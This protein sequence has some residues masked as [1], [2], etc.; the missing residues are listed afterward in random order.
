MALSPKELEVL[1]ETLRHYDQNPHLRGISPKGCV[2]RV[3][4]E[5]A[6]MCAVGRCLTPEAS[7]VA[8][9][10]NATAVDVL[11]ERLH[12]Y[13]FPMDKGFDDMFQ[14]AYRDLDVAFWLELQRVHDSSDIWKSH[15]PGFIRTRTSCAF[16]EEAFPV[17]VRQLYDAGF[18]TDADA[19]VVAYLKDHA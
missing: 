2:Y 8:V 7:D 17:S 1:I 12:D 18:F 10:C 9:R 5:P 13:G 16:L 11:L 19:E 6:R 14:P 4:D 15:A 3:P